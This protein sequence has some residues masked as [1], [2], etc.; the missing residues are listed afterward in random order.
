MAGRINSI[1]HR[2]RNGWE[3]W[4]NSS[5][6]APPKKNQTFPE[7]SKG[8]K[9][10]TIG[11]EGRPVQLALKVSVGSSNCG[12]KDN[13][14]QKKGGRGGGEKKIG[15][16]YPWKKTGGSASR[17]GKGDADQGQ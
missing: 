8:K 12:F 9:I 6:E 2:G 16:R 11:G 13:T 4:A 7:N 15:K 5:G 10:Q 17:E 3:G 14:A 1:I